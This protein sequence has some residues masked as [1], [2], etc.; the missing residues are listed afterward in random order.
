MGAFIASCCHVPLFN[1]VDFLGFVGVFTSFL[2]E[3]H[4]QFDGPVC[5]FTEKALEDPKGREKDIFV[6]DFLWKLVRYYP[7]RKSGPFDYSLEPVYWGGDKKE[8]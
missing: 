8:D 3:N 5:M 6:P 4:K 1:T 7:W 2:D